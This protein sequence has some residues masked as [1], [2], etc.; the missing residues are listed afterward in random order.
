MYFH[1]NNLQLR[2]SAFKTSLATISLCGDTVVHYQ[3]V[4]EAALKQFRFSEWQASAE[5]S[6]LNLLAPM[7]FVK[8]ESAKFCKK[9]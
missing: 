4:S 8:I 2:F 7:A 3:S 5:A 6:L 1:I 9:P